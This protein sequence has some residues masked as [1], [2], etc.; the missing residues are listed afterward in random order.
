MGGLQIYRNKELAI[1]QPPPQEEIIFLRSSIL[2]L[3]INPRLNLLGILFSLAVTANSFAQVQ[4]AKFLPIAPQSNAFYEYLPSGYPA[5][6]VKYPLLIFMHGMGELGV[7]NAGTLPLILQHG[8]PKLINNGTFP[9]SFTVNNQTYK[10]IVLSPQFTAWPTGNDIESVITYAKNNYSIDIN[11]IYLTGLSMGGGAIWSYSGSSLETASRIAAILPVAGAS[12]TYAPFAANMA[13]ADLPVWATH[14]IG[15]NIV[16]VSH[17]NNHITA[18]NTQANPPSPLARKTIFPGASHDAWSQT[19]DPNFRENGLNAYEWLLTNRRNFSVLPVTG[20]ELTAGLSTG[21]KVNLAWTTTSEINTQGFSVLRSNEGTI[22]NSLGFVASTGI[23]G[24]GSTYSFV[25]NNP[26]SGNN[27]YRLEA[28]DNDGQKSYSDVKLVDL[29]SSNS[30][31]FYPNP[32][33]NVLNIRTSGVFK[34]T[35]LRISNAAGQNV[36]QQLLNGTGNIAVAV[37]AL[38]PGVYYGKIIADNKIERF[39]FIKE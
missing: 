13:N 36:V 3:M 11:R 35:Q 39:K 8:P 37:S 7:G 18:I 24:A 5:A 29:L 12:E 31:S 17:T 9:Q 26:L 22:F 16:P 21:R 30:I 14:N 15:D 10:F 1:L 38:P 4:T 23:N 32:T 33:K 28:R 19:Y 2:F 6:G 25:D 20:L 27:F 34:N